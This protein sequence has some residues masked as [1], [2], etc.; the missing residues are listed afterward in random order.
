[1][2][3]GANYNRRI[4]IVTVPRWGLSTCLVILMI[5]S[6]RDRNRTG[7]MIFVILSLRDRRAGSH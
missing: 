2:H 3:P 6:L 5:L 4:Y 7:Q 1:M